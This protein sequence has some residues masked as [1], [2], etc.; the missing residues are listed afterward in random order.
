MAHSTTSMIV[1]LGRKGDIKIGSTRGHVR[2]AH[3]R[4]AGNWQ[5]FGPI[6]PLHQALLK[7]ESC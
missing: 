3:F 1:R 4:P 2:H 5:V 6:C 7:D